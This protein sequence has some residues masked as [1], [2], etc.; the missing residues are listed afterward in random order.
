MSS[1]HPDCH[2]PLAVHAHG[3]QEEAREAALRSIVR[4][5]GCNPNK[6]ASE[7][8]ATISPIQGALL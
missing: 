4:M 6:P 7:L 8:A 2:C 1:R 5:A 3:Q